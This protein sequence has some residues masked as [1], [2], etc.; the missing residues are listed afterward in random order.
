L[1][2]AMPFRIKRAAPIQSF[3]TDGTPFQMDGNDALGDCTCACLGNV[4]DVVKR[5]LGY[6][7]GNIPDANVVQ[8]ATAHGF[9][10]GADIS[11]VLEALTTDP[12]IDASG[13]ANT[14]GPA[15]G[16]NY[17]DMPTVYAALAE[18]Y[19]LDLGVDSSLYTQCVGNIGTVAVAPLITRALSNYDHSIPAFADWGTAEFLAAKYSAAYNQNVQLGDLPA[20]TP[21]I[22]NETW[23]C[24]VIV[25]VVSFQLSTGEAW[26]PQSYPAPVPAPPTPPTPPGPTPTPTRRAIELAL[27]AA[28]L[29]ECGIDVGQILALAEGAINTKEALLPT[30]D[31]A[32]RAAA[33]KARGEARP[34]YEQ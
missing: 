25:P 11:D 15:L 7:G 30:G 1:L 28:R 13:Q 10:N 31:Y 17:N 23:G 3:T 27:R 33:A 6:S 12:M 22:G 34:Q 29:H 9:Q 5:V 16:V 24:P 14:I 21:C 18:H 8:W 2:D 26:A 4:L 20:D 19:A 32:A